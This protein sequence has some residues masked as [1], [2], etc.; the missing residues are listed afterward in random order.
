MK[1]KLCGMFREED[2][3]SVN[4]LLPDFI[5]FVFAKS[6]RQISIETATKFK[7]ILHP[8]IK[9][10]GVF[11]NEELKVIE[12]LAKNKIIDYIQLHGMETTSYVE[13][14]SKLVTIP[15]IKAFRVKGRQE[16]M[17]EM[18]EFQDT[19]VEY[20]LLDSFELGVMGGT[21]TPFQWE[22]IPTITKPFFLAGG[23]TSNNIIEAIKYHPYCLDLSS[24]IETDG[25]KDD[26][27]MKE[28]VQIV[29]EASDE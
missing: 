12:M 26:H 23:L 1:I 19:N 2:I 5:G 13:E 8:T 21:G 16:L 20:F 24:G 10:V 4:K 9:V 11:V 18:L 3:I 7:A 6:K 27:K 14:L 28:V 25:R 22:E 29:R 17:Q 15:I